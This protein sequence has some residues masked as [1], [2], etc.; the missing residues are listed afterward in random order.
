VQAGEAQAGEF[1]HQGGA[2]AA[3]VGGE[4]GQHFGVAALLDPLGAQG[5]Q[6][7]ADVDLHRGSE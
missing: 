7:G 3:E 5:R 2:L 1:V 4:A 6:A